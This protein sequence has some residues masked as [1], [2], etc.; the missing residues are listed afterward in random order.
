MTQDEIL[1]ER[2]QLIALCDSLRFDAIALKTRLTDQGN[3]E[4]AQDATEFLAH[5][6]TCL[7]D[8]DPVDER[9]PIII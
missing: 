6:L 4:A 9:G 5:A 8:I 3:R 7:R 2:D 1:H